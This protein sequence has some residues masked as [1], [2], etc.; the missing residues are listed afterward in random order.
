MSIKKI[1]LPIDDAHDDKHVADTAFAL[2]EAHGAEIDGLLA[3]PHDW[4]SEWFDSYGLSASELTELNAQV[5]RATQAAIER[6]RNA[7]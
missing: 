2:A 6:A 7:F 4:Q 1:L 3:Q 5:K